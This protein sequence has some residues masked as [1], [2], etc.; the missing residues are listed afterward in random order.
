MTNS[1]NGCGLCCRLFLINLNKE[2][3]QSGQYRTMFAG[4]DPI[5]DFALAKDCGANLLAKKADGGC[6]YLDGNLCGI[7]ETRPKVCRDFFCTSRAKKFAGMVKIIKE[8]D[9][10]KISSVLEVKT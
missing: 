4:L 10:E 2:E 1:C 6:V 3:Y 9:K 7:H 5:T 8:N